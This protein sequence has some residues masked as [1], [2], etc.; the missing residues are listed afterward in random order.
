MAFHSSTLAWRIPWTQE[1]GS[2]SLWGHKESDT[3]ERLHF[4]FLLG[5]YHFCSL[6]SPSLHEMFPLS[7]FLEEISSLSQSIVFLCFFALIAEEGFLISP[8]YSLGLC[9]Q[10]GIS[11]LFSFAFRISSFHS[12]L[13]GLLRQS[14][15][16]FAFLFLGG[17]LDKYK[18]GGELASTVEMRN[19]EVKVGN[20]RQG[21]QHVQRIIMSD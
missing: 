8:C 16:L 1:P 7:N 9:F 6:L 4:H 14:F 10:M 15:C 2:Y 17:A 20:S 3:T 5:P 11:F 13:K 19:N 18:Y 21:E 12:Y